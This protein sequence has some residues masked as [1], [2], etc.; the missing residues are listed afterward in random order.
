MGLPLWLI[1]AVTIVIVILILASISAYIYRTTLVALFVPN[2]ETGGGTPYKSR[3]KESEV[4][5]AESTPDSIGNPENREA[6]GL[7]GDVVVTESFY[8]DSKEDVGGQEIGDRLQ[9]EEQQFVPK[10]GFELGSPQK[11]KRSFE[12]ETTRRAATDATYNSDPVI[13]H[14]RSWKIK[15]QGIT[16]NEPIAAEGS[17]AKAELISPPQKINDN[18]PAAALGEINQSAAAPPPLKTESPLKDVLNQKS[19]NIKK[20]SSSSS[21][22]EF[23]SNGKDGT[24]L[25]DKTVLRLS[26]KLKEVCN[27]YGNEK[28]NE[29]DIRSITKRSIEWTVRSME[30]LSDQIQKINP[31]TDRE[32]L[33]PELLKS[34]LTYQHHNNPYKIILDI[35]NFINTYNQLNTCYWASLMLSDIKKIIITRLT[36]YINRVIKGTPIPI[37]RKNC[38]NKYLKILETYY[39]SLDATITTKCPATSRFIKHF[40]IINNPIVRDNPAKAISTYLEEYVNKS[41]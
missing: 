5:D 39:N 40:T 13:E 41:Q 17:L 14:K 15:P 30:Y 37:A 7:A 38:Y 22:I 18:S 6:A 19:G 28:I 2:A 23:P 26:S 35:N 20:S 3:P 34:L 32:T 29:K 1:I 16:Q 27:P 4:V 25:L 24:P 36:G 10:K 9:L 11:P 31:N 12:P 21:K 8:I 33:P